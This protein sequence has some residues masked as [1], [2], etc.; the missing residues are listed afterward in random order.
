MR[1]QDTPV[2]S[3][4]IRE[5]DAAACFHEELLEPNQLFFFEFQVDFPS[6]NV[7]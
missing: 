4:Y 6:Q 7:A 3:P 1:F 5:T 2:D